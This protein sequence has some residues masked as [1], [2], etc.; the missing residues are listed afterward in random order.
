MVAKAFALLLLPVY[1]RELTRAEYGTAE[2]LLTAIITRL[3]RRAPGRSSRRSCA[4]TSST[5][6]RCS[7]TASCAPRPASSVLT[8][9]AAALAV[10]RVRRPLS[11]LILGHER[12]ADL[13]ITALGSG[14]S[15][16]SSRP[17]RCC[18]WT[19][20][21]GVPDRSIANVRAHD[22]RS[23]CSSSCRDEGARGLLLGNF[24]ASTR[25]SCSAC[26]GPARPRSGSCRDGAGAPAA[27]CCASAC[28]PCRPRSRSSPST[29]STGSTSTA[30]GAAG[31]AGLY[32]LRGQ[33]RGGGHR[34]RAR[35][36][37]R[38][39]PL[40]YSVEDDDEAA[41]LYAFV[42]TYYVLVTGLVVARDDAARPLGAAAVRRAGVLRRA[43][44]AAVGR[45][46]LGAL[47]PVPDLVTIGRARAGARR[48]TSPPR[49]RAG[50]QRRRCW[51]CSSAPLGI[52]GAGIAL[53]AA[54]VVMVVVDVP[55]HAAAVPGAV[56]VGPRSCTLVVV[57]GGITV[58]GELLL[59]DA[60]AA[61][62]VRAGAG[63]GRH[64]RRA[65]RHRL[66]TRGRDAAPACTGVA[67]GRGA[68]DVAASRA[69]A[70]AVSCPDR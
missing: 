1:T 15:P 2:L 37:V 62:F 32:S 51:C 49:P 65:P 38:W 70:T 9:T 58:A 6:T 67:R 23:R 35:V 27:R 36:P 57:I 11:E 26:G 47:R 68:R 69:R 17:T 7:A 61:G 20:A 34:R 48:A 59:P 52:A 46:G 16:T 12:H 29:S 63:A 13:R 54:Y 19:S 25:S 21:R 8:T 41:R 42:A 66:P 14:R 18:A 44:G 56:R 39:P 22:R 50:R 4:S 28:R 45:A 3:D 5:R 31:A 43:R 10:A 60:G 40:A 55:A 64:P 53:C 24:A 33:A 30:H